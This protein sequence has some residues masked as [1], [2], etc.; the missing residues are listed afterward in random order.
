M[1]GKKQSIAIIFDGWHPSW[2]SWL[3]DWCVHYY[4]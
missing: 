3:S 1:P 4:R 2:H